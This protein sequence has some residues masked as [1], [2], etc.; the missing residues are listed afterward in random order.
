MSRSQLKKPLAG[1]G[2]GGFCAEITPPPSPLA[3]VR[4]K[5]NTEPGSSL[6][7][8][9]VCESARNQNGLINLMIGCARGIRQSRQLRKR[10]RESRR[11]G[12]VVVSQSDEAGR[13]FQVRVGLLYISRFLLLVLEVLLLFSHR[14]ACSIFRGQVMTR[15]SFFSTSC[16]PV[17]N[18]AFLSF[19]F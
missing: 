5:K 19:F 17:K 2:G 6:M 3:L 9:V 12:A 1:G 10:A 15:S 4:L 7:S 11:R 14:T 16:S 18:K 13:G 8:R